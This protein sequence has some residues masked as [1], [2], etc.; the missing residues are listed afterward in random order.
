MTEWLSTIF[1]GWGAW[2]AAIA[3]VVTAATA[4]TALTPTQVDD[5]VV[6]FFLR[7]LNVLAG[8]V[9]RNANADDV[10]PRG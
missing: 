3:S 7:V 1:D 6:N 4:I 2:V 10:P 5:K 8:N 9:G